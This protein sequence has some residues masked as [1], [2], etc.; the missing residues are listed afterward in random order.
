MVIRI[1]QGKGRK[2]HYRALS[3]QRLYE[4]RAYLIKYFSCS[5]STIQL[6]SSYVLEI[7]LKSE[8]VRQSRFMFYDW[9]EDEFAP[10]QTRPAGNDNT[11]QARIVAPLAKGPY[12]M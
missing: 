11:L 3:E 1:E 10:G 9:K 2:D 4:L 7:L 5:C 12:K 8:E 6:G